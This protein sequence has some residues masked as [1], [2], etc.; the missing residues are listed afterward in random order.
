VPTPWSKISTEK[1]RPKLATVPASDQVNTLPAGFPK[2]VV[3]PTAWSGADIKND[4]SPER[5][6]LILTQDQITELEQACSK[7]QGMRRLSIV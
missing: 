4:P 3:S 7:F 2:F 1:L 5:C 6:T